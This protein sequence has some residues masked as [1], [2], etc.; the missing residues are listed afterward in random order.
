MPQRPRC[1]S[2]AAAACTM[3]L[4]NIWKGLRGSV[5][6]SDFRLILDNHQQKRVSDQTYKCP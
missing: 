3:H 2:N 4:P 1:L 5:Y 6:I